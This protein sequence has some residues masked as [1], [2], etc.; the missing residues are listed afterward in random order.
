[1]LPQRHDEDFQCVLGSEPHQHAQKQGSRNLLVCNAIMFSVA[2]HPFWEEVFNKLLDRV[3]ELGIDTG[4]WVSPVDTT[5]P[6]MLSEIYE[7]QPMSYGDVAVY[8]STAFYPLKDNHDKYKEIQPDDPKYRLS[9]AVHR[10]HHLWLHGNK[11][12]HHHEHHDG[13]GGGGDGGGAVS[14]GADP[15]AG[16]ANGEGRYHT[17]VWQTSP[18]SL[19][20]D[21][22]GTRPPL[23]FTTP[24][25]LPATLHDSAGEDVCVAYGVSTVTTEGVRLCAHA[26]A[27][28]TNSR[29]PLSACRRCWSTLRSRRSRVQRKAR[30]SGARAGGMRCGWMPTLWRGSVG[31]GARMSWAGCR[32]CGEGGWSSAPPPPAPP[33]LR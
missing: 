4:E 9:W 24:R 29:S 30:W 25:I 2:R 21:T 27:R 11:H 15:A 6:V 3:P 26:H 18:K 13:G 22:S 17:K 28:C 31:R 32:S 5:G 23:L 1:V 12:H 14:W 20:A 19:G 16:G 10:W 33:R 7:S 8:P